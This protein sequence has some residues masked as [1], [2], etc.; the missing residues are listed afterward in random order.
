MLKMKTILVWLTVLTLALSLKVFAWDGNSSWKNPY[1]DSSLRSFYS[2]TLHPPIEIDWE[3][4]VKMP[5]YILCEGDRLVSASFDQLEIY[6]ISTQER[7][8]IIKV[9]TQIKPCLFDN[10]IFVARRNGIQAFRLSDGIQVFER[11]FDGISSILSS[12]LGILVVHKNLI[13]ILGPQGDQVGLIELQ[14]EV[15]TQPAIWGD[16]MVYPC[17][18]LKIRGINIKTGEQIFGTGIYGS[19]KQ[20][21]VLP[22]NVF[23]VVFN[24]GGCAAFDLLTGENLW[25]DKEPRGDN[26]LLAASD[27]LVIVYGS[28]SGL[29][30]KRKEGSTNWYS[31]RFDVRQI[32]VSGRLL[33]TATKDNSLQLIQTSTG[34]V[35]VKI[36]LPGTVSSTMA[37]LGASVYMACGPKLIRFI[38]SPYKAYLG[39]DGELDF[40]TLRPGKAHK[41]SLRV[42]NLSNR[43]F[44]TL[45]TTKLKDCTV[46][47]QIITLKPGEERLVTF[48]IL[49]TAIL[50]H[51]EK[52]V[53]TV[54]TPFYRYLLGVSYIAQQLPGDANLDCIVDVTDVIILGLHYGETSVSKEFKTEYDL[55]RDGRI[56]FLDLA[57]ITQNLGRD[58]R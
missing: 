45:F 37:Q 57:I 32:M 4:S 41:Q 50:S 16:T 49:T 6:T 48:T 30:C 26:L 15:E 42:T 33:L 28:S 12:D 21:A 51:E 58:C 22:K 46:S 40:G 31:N 39:F 1:G 29:I 11:S 36:A 25:A 44:Q 13:T 9:D 3:D 54:D 38:T 20:I 10:L 56:D 7:T 35:S 47:P 8:A 19:V 17:T 43:S 53:L 52:D 18:D 23:V 55:N 2:R 14:E 24:K 5:Q 27:S 34:A